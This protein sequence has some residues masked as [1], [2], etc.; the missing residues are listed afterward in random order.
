MKLLIVTRQQR[1][2]SFD[3]LF[4]R[5]AGHFAQ[6]DVHKLTKAQVH[7]I[8]PYLKH[9]DFSAW[10]RVLFDVPLRRIGNAS[11]A[12]RTIQGLVFYEEDACQERVAESKFSQQFATG[13]G[14]LTNA[15]IIVTSYFMRDYFIARGIDACCIP[16]AYDD[17]VLDALD[18]PR[19]ISLGF[20]G[21]TKSQVYNER[22]HLLERMET[23]CGLQTL[24]TQTPDEYL[25][26]LNR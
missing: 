17:S 2:R 26:L 25:H 5:L 24:R 14:E 18:V 11:K 23:L 19:D 20:I 13:F 15:R 7:D 9:T 21:R 10:D 1:A 12:L 4:A 16:K 6:V 8:R 3:S 22:R